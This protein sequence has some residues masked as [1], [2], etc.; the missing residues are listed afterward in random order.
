MLGRIGRFLRN[1]V[2]PG[3]A[4]RGSEKV[5]AHAGS[6]ASASG[7]AGLAGLTEDAVVRSRGRTTLGDIALTR[8]LDESTPEIARGT[9][10]GA[11]FGPI[12]IQTRGTPE[13]EPPATESIGGKHDVSAPDDD[14]D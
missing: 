11:C 5:R 3:A 8:E 12:E 7:S 6:G 2:R 9:A 1:V 4:D 14:E 10:S 13:D